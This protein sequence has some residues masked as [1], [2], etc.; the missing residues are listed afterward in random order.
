MN[1]NQLSEREIKRKEEYRERYSTLQNAFPQINMEKF[2][3]NKTIDELCAV[4]ARNMA[5][6]IIWRE[7]QF[8]IKN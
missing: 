8:F 3:V 6:T 4:Y 7:D 2:D 5:R 1:S